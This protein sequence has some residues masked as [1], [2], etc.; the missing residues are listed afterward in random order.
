MEA[1]SCFNWTQCW[2]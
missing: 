2:L 1:F